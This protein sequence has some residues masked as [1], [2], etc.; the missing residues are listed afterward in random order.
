MDA[1]IIDEGEIEAIIKANYE[2]HNLCVVHEMEWLEDKD[3]SNNGI[4]KKKL[5]LKFKGE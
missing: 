1:T 5:L 4:P 3:Y 2:E